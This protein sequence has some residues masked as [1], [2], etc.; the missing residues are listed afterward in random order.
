MAMLSAEQRAR[1][2]DTIKRAKSDATS[3]KGELMR[4]HTK[5]FNTPGCFAEARRLEAII[6][7]LEH[8]QNT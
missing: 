4:L 1:R 3:A 2:A 8:W 7:R 6:G 5:L